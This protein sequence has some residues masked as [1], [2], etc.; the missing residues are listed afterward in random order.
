MK[1]SAS[2]L[3]TFLC[4]ILCFTACQTAPPAA[5]GNADSAALTVHDGT[6]TGAAK[7]YGGELTVE[8]TTAAGK[9]TAMEIKQHNESPEYGGRAV[10]ELPT[11]I[12]EANSLGVDAISGATITSRAI[13]RAA[14]SAIAKA[15]GDPKAYDY[16]AVEEISASDVVKFIGL[17]DGKA[18]EFT[19]EQLMAMESVTVDATSVNASGSTA[20]IT[21]TGVTLETILQSL[22]TSQKDYEAIIAT[23][24]DGYSIEIPKSVLQTRDVIIAWNVNGEPQSPR[25][26]VPKERAMYWVKF[27]STFELKGEIERVPVNTIN[28]METMLAGLA[29]KAE[30][31]K[32]YDTTDKAIPVSVVFE[33]YI[34]AKPEFVT[35]NSIDQWGKNDKFDTVAAQYIKFTGEDAPLFIG[36]NLPE[37]MRLKNML[38]MQI[39]NENIISAAM[40]MKKENIPEGEAI[41]LS[42]LLEM[43][44]MTDASSYDF[45][46][47]DDYTVE[48]QKADIEK[49]SVLIREGAVRVSFEGLEKN[50]TVKNLLRIKANVG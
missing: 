1:K 16:T 46:A 28:V 41:P 18:A 7:G 49:G 10:D 43:S 31:Y 5:Q 22:G 37:G 8:V 23:A 44:D 19:G 2:I 9:I 20:D 6:F 34:T 13:F 12:V 47:A 4:M 32:Y 3:A 38:T 42:K 17:P 25:T 48:I 24:T 11:K 40:A 45:T 30:D 21:A 50:T 15:G 29:D 36:P 33:K 26:I 14:S 39:A 27:L 35:L